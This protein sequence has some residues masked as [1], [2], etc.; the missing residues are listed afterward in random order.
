M[1]PLFCSKS[2]VRLALAWTLIGILPM[3][4]AQG[5]G[6]LSKHARK[7][8]KT[9]ER[10]AAGSYLH[11]ELSDGTDLYG[12]LGSLAD[13]SFGFVDSDNNATQSVTYESVDHVRRDAPTVSRGDY[14]HHHGRLL[15]V[16]LVGAAAAA[17]FAVYEVYVK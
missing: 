4:Q 12:T 7:V 3:C 17:G 11:L 1:N 9:L 14:P 10:Y 6:N 2:M 15:K 16:V 5:A 13:T 8:H